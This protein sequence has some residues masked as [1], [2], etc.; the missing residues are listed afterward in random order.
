[1]D[2]LCGK[3]KETLSKL[4]LLTTDTESQKLRETPKKLY[5]ISRTTEP[6]S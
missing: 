4:E 6:I 1:M 2:A 5:D 3:P